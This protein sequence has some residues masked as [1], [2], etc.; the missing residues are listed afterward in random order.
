MGKVDSFSFRIPEADE[1]VSAWQEEINEAPV[2]FF[3]P[4]FF[5]DLFR[6]LLTR[7]TSRLTRKSN[8]RGRGPVAMNSIFF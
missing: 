3:C 2:F 7:S 1:L 4:S 5:W 6:I 8:K